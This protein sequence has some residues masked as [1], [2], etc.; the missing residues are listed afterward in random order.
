LASNAGEGYY[1]AIESSA[2][3]NTNPRIEQTVVHADR[4]VH[5][6]Y[7]EFFHGLKSIDKHSQ[8]H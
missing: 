1:L 3:V 7:Q 2:N 8:T 6:F 5:D 4:A